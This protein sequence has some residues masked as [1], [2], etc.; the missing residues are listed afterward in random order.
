[1]TCCFIHFTRAHE[2]HI[3]RLILPIHTEIDRGKH[4]EIFIKRVTDMKYTTLITAAFLSIMF[5]VAYAAEDDGSNEVK[6]YCYERVDQAGIED[7]NEKNQYMKEC[8][9]SFDVSAAEKSAVE[10][11]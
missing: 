11:N 4:F 2:S 9:E 5:N 10:S 7:A 1:M 3:N 6:D 8:L